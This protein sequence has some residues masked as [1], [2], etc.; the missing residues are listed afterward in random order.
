MKIPKRYKDA[1]LEQ[2]EPSARKEVFD[3]LGKKKSFML[4][5]DVGT[6]KTHTAYAIANHMNQPTE[7]KVKVM[8]LPET[9]S[10][11]RENMT[12]GL[13]ETQLRFQEEIGFTKYLV[14]DD[15]GA[16]KATDWAKE[17]IY[18]IINH[19]YEEMLPTIVTSNLSL[20]QLSSHLGER[21][22]SRLAEMCEV[23]ELSGKDRRL[24]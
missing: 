23:V 11:L 17:T 6:G 12:L 7:P 20:G 3:L 5:G 24:D 22:A 21:I 9:M 4:F 18:S 15:L 1:D 10:Y 2:I 14:L 8:N 16:E 13:I 19:R